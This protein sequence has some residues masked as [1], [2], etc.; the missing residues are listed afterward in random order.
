MLFYSCN[1]VF[2]LLAFHCKKVF[3]GPRTENMGSGWD[4]AFFSF[5]YVG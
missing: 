4:L 1:N 5:D 2:F 3:P